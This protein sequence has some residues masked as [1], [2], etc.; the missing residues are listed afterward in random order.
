MVNKADQVFAH[1]VYRLAGKAAWLQTW[2]APKWANA[3]SLFA[4]LSISVDHKPLGLSLPP[5]SSSGPCPGPRPS[6]S[7]L[8]LLVKATASG[9]LLTR[10]TSSAFQLAPSPVLHSSYSF[11]AP[12]FLKCNL[13]VPLPSLQPLVG[14]LPGNTPPLGVTYLLF[15]EVHSMQLTLPYPLLRHPL[16]PATVIRSQTDKPGPNRNVMS[17]SWEGNEFPLS[18][19]FPSSWRESLQRWRQCMEGSRG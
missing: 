15:G 9:T 2:H 11:Y 14:H 13:I 8:S 3:T 17:R 4:N 12:I 7:L 6:L 16:L 18:C 19:L 5:A 1:R 10:K